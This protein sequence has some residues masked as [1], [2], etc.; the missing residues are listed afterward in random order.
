MGKAGRKLN[1]KVSDNDM[2]LYIEEYTNKYPNEKI[3]IQ[4]LAEF[5]GIERHYW[6][7]RKGFR[8][9]IEDIN[10]ISYE[11]YDIIAEEDTKEVRL[12]NV[13]ELVDNNFRNKK[14]L[15]SK[16]NSFFITYQELYNLSCDSYKLRNEIGRLKNKLT[17][18]EKEIEKLKSEKKHYKEL[19]EYN[20]KR[21]FE[22]AVRS[23]E[24]NY[25]KE[26]NIKNN[27]IQIDNRNEK[28]YSTNKDDLDS[29]LNLIED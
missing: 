15:K 14:A 8:E 23:R 29:L 4:K 25:R 1:E 26:N 24:A 27:V 20:E 12:P 16:L 19:S 22:I 13:D 3:N 10:N 6:Y 21:Y 5:S 28:A 17:K 9:K 7:S 2:L 18:S 11:E